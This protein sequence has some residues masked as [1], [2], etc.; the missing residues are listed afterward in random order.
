MNYFIA[1]NF[2]QFHHQLSLMKFYPAK[3]F[4]YTVLNLGQ[5][6]LV[7]LIEGK[8]EPLRLF[9]GAFPS[10]STSGELH[11]VALAPAGCNIIS[12]TD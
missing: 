11:V 8:A 1:G 2:C 12:A 7:L 10:K 4:G 3:I 5:H 9:S 6:T